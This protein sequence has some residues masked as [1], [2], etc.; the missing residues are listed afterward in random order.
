MYRLSALLLVVLMACGPRPEP[1]QPSFRDSAAQI[2]S[3]AVLQTDRLEGHW[4]QVAGFAGAAMPCG[5]G[6]VDIA[7]GQVH[8]SL[9]L[10]SMRSGEGA[11]VPGKAGRFAVA[12]MEDWWLLWVDGD[13]RTM[14]VGT[15]TGHFG[16][17]L[18]RDGGL[19]GDR[20]TAVRDILQ[21]NGYDIGR[22]RFY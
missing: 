8:W 15:P 6:A 2:Y 7:G 4:V 16:F 12:G 3:S 11:M 13:Y 18:N 20:A 9:C 10:D 19:P 21:F 17:V 5:P 22:L 1:V 14:V